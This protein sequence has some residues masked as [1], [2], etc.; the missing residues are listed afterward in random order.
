MRGGV[1]AYFFGMA[2]SSDLKLQSIPL[3]AAFSRGSPTYMQLWKITHKNK[4]FNMKKCCQTIA[5]K[6]KGMSTVAQSLI[7]QK[8]TVTASF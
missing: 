1:S 2:L 8:P 3:R 5:T 7:L 6:K 4:N